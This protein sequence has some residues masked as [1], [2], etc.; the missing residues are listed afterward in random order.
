MTMHEWTGDD[1]RPWIR[2]A[3]ETFGADR[4]MFASNFPVDWLYSSYDAL[5]EAFHESTIDFSAGD[6]DGLFASNAERIYR[7]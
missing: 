1:L 6:R 5:L 4:C 2:T 3:I 7:F